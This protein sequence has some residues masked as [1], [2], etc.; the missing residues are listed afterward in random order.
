MSANLD[1]I[2]S[3]LTTA[4]IVTAAWPAHKLAAQDAPDQAVTLYETGGPNDQATDRAWGR[5]TFQVVA[6]ALTAKL[7][8]DK[9]EAVRAALDRAVVSGFD[10]VVATQAAPTYLGPDEKGRPRFGVNFRSG[11]D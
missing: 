10:H 8:S 7:A 1:A 4:G 5:P 11:E 3:H 2:A 6:R 9:A